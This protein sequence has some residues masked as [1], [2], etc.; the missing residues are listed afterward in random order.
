MNIWEKRII[1]AMFVPHSVT[2]EQQQHTA[3]THED[4]V[5]TVELNRIFWNA[6][7]L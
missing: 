6:S 4:F 2:E 7:L 3:K 1:S 5:Q